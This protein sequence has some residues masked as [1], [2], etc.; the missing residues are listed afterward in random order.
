MSTSMKLDSDL[1]LFRKDLGAVKRDVANLIEHVKGGA[2]S[3]VQIAG[4]ELKRRVR[5]LRQQ[6]GAEGDRTARAFNLFLQNEPLVA[7]SIAVGIGYV[8]TRVLR[9]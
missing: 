6:S 5:N 9:W 7:L 4:G 3:T 8:G 1:E 2:A